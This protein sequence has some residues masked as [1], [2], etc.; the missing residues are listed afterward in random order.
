MSYGAVADSFP[1]VNVV[2]DI[3]KKNIT[4]GKYVSLASLL[5]PDYDTSR[6]ILDNMTGID[7]L[8]HQQRDH[9]LNRALSITQFYK[10]FSTYKSVIFEVFSLRE[11]E[12]NLYE[13]NIGNIYEPYGGDFYQYHVTFF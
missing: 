11:D 12:L 1:H 8:K 7:L 3:I 13:A 9:R 10:T 6:S 5:I 2:S 4:S